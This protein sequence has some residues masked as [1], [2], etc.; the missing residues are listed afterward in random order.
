MALLQNPGFVA[1][2]SGVEKTASGASYYFIDH[3]VPFLMVNEGDT[4]T[5]TAD[6]NQASVTSIRWEEA[7]NADFGT[8]L[9]ELAF[10]DATCDTNSNT[11]VNCDSTEKMV[12][13]QEVTG[14]GIPADTTVSSITNVTTF[15]ISQ[16]ATSSLTN[17]TL[18]FTY[19]DISDGLTLALTIGPVKES[20][21][22]RPTATGGGG[23]WDRNRYYR[24][25]IVHSG[26]TYYS[27]TTE[28]M[29][30]WPDPAGTKR[31]SGT[32]TTADDP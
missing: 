6:H 2:L 19:S 22:P 14:S 26:A 8:D 29:C 23:R 13:G 27:S 32:F 12:V 17:T 11:T 7:S 28:V 1:M 10:T 5:L 25:K 30:D 24:C 18:T 31:T 3:P 20:R 21:F 15:V 16:D 9:V 4:F